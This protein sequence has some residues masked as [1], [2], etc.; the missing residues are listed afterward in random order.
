MKNK[1]YRSKD[2]MVGGVCAGLGEYVGI[3]PT[4]VRLA[5]ALLLF[6]DGCVLLAYIIGW[7]VIA[8]DPE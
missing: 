6:F 7:I 5:F 4:I 2:Q 1:L 8:E 3:D